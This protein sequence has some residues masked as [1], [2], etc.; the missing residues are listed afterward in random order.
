MR[1]K[2][3]SR[4]FILLP[5]IDAQVR[6]ASKNILCPITDCPVLLSN[7]YYQLLSVICFGKKDYCSID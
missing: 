3:T 2:E 1:G 6:F 7:Y 4:A 5:E